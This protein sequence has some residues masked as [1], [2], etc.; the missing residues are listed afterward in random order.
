MFAAQQHDCTVKPQPAVGHS[1]V[2][3]LVCFQFFENANGGAVTQQN[4]SGGVTNEALPEVVI[5]RGEQQ[6]VSFQSIHS[7]A[8]SELHPRRS[9]HDSQK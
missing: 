6:S 8:I 5:M 7:N 3:T 2:H 9:R 4:L 1:R